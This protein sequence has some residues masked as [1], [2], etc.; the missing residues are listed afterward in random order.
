MLIVLR[1]FPVVVVMVFLALHALD[2]LLL[3]RL[4]AVHERDDAQIGVVHACEHVAHP[5][6]GLAADVDE[7]VRVAD[8]DDVL[9]RRLVGVHLAAGL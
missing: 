6:I 4:H 7:H 5:Y 1:L 9:G 3:Q 2:G 8:G